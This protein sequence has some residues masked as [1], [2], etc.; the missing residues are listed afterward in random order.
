M[1]R[2]VGI[3][4]GAIVLACIGWSAWWYVA[5]RSERQGVEAW[6]AEQR[7]QGW[8]AEAA[9][10][11]VTG[12]PTDLRLTLTGL[13]L[14]DPAT[15][16]AWAAPVLVAESKAWSPTTVAV[17]WP[18]EQTVSVP[19]ERVVVGTA[20]MESLIDLR[21]GPSLELRQAATELTGLAVESSA[22]WSAAADA[23]SIRI[24]ERPE[25]LA[26]PNSYDVRITADAL[27]LPEGLVDR[28]DP[29]GWLQPRVDRVTVIGHVALADPIGL[30]T[31]E[32]G[33]IALRAAS[34]REVGFEWGE[35]KLVVS[36]AFTVDDQGYPDGQIEV[37]AREWRQMV[38]LAVGSGVIGEETARAVTQA[39]EF[40]TMLTGGGDSLS[41]PFNLS[42]GKLR[43]G[44]VAVADLPRLAPP[45][46]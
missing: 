26:P 6:L 33:D 16:W 34:L 3:I 22:G 13:A 42:G 27:R 15:G 8:Q 20:S 46:G 31:V 18:P 2:L 12:F 41:A 9:S 37:E 10:I 36:G 40:I 30:A 14:A 19:G 44:P 21:P 28:L 11:E 7:A 32:T 25:D 1:R 24:A 5:A 29:T 23:A 43:I 38:R 45:R 35:M 17:D 39:I 4:T